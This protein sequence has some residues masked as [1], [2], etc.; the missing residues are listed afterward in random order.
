SPRGG[1]LCFNTFNNSNKNSSAYFESHLKNTPNT[2]LSQGA[3]TSATNL[4]HN[5]YAHAGAHFLKSID[6]TSLDL[7]NIKPNEILD[8]SVDTNFLKNC[9]VC[10]SCKRVEKINRGPLLKSSDIL[11]IV[12]SDTWG[13]CRVSGIYG[14]SYFVTFTDEASRES[15]LYLLKSTKEVAD[16]F[17]R[18]KD[19]KE[20]QSGRKIKAMRFDGGSE[21][22]TIKFG[23]ILQQVS[24]PYTQHQ[25]GVSERLNRTLITMSRCMLNH[26]GLPLRFWDAA[27]L[28]ACYLRN[29]LPLLPD[30]KTPYEVMNGIVPKISH[31]KVWGCICFVLIDTHDPRRFKLS[32]TSAKGIFIGYC[33][34]STQYRV[35]VPSK[36]GRDKIVVSANVH[37]LEDSFW[38]WG[39]NSS[40]LHEDLDIQADEVQNSL[41]LTKDQDLNSSSDSDSDSEIDSR[42]HSNDIPNS[43]SHSSPEPNLPTLTDNNTETSHPELSLSDETQ[44]SSRNVSEN[45]PEVPALRR[46]SR[47][48][49]PIE[50]RSAWQPKSR[51]LYVGGNVP[52]PQTYKEAINGINSTDWK[53]AINEELQ[54]LQEK[55]VFS[56]VTHVPHGRK[57]IGFR[58]VFTVKSDGRFKARLVA[59]G[60]SQIYGVD[61]FDT[62]S[63]TLRADSLRILLA[64]AT[65]LDWEIDQ[66]DVKTAYLE[67]DLDE[68]IFMKSPDGLAGTK[69]VQVNKALYGLKQSGRAWYDKLNTRLLSLDFK[70]S[71]SDQCV[72]INSASQIIIG[73]YVD[74]LVIC[75]KDSQ[76]IIILKQEL[77]SSFP[78]KDIGSIDTVIGWKVT[79]NRSTRTLTISQSDYIRDKIN[80]FGLGDAKSYYSPLNG[81]DGILPANNGEALADETAYASAVGSLGY[82]SSGSRPDIA[83]ATSQLGRFNSAPVKRH[84]DSVCRVL[85]YLKGSEK[86]YIKYNFGPTSED[87]TQEKMAAL[88]S[89]SDF[90]S[91]TATRHS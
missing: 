16:N 42:L 29:R 62:Y 69:F 55:K 8:F 40:A 24:A 27:V 18:Y 48:R 43:L 70:R 37:F 14:S 21:F 81:Y 12:H 51:A 1:L 31:L 72:Y 30:K 6:I 32:P 80:S 10:L 13:K 28:T 19:K 60:F 74:D 9:N 20:L 89:D 53:N 82:A 65:F 91:D 22:K 66:I 7:P 87:L 86:Y 56:P 58:W 11:E 47:I 45:N 50:P 78:I 85:R 34:S 90:A 35:Y 36:N 59:Q 67:G 23:G 73:V 3:K 38:D 71:H 75:G 84:W 83:F 64:V 44:D 76:N 17:Y 79:R 2:L 54:S 39:I 77:A 61:Y 41:D 4:M 15:E 26:S 52:I 63:P 46:S 88:Y 25:N 5:R 33:E 49:I 68:V 57:P